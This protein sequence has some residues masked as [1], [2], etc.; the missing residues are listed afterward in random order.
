M[1]VVKSIFLQCDMRD[2]EQLES[3][4][5]ELLEVLTADEVLFT[6]LKVGL[7]YCVA[8]EGITDYTNELNTRVDK[9]FVAAEKL[10]KALENLT[11]EEN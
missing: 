4:A 8:F 7:T 6:A 2:T 5:S 3:A 10:S 11:D 1:K 9:L